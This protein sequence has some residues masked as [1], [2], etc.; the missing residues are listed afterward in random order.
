MEDQGNHGQ[1]GINALSHTDSED[2]HR[3]LVYFCISVKR[4]IALACVAG[5]IRD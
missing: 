2:S 5:G 3:R 4:I 1:Q